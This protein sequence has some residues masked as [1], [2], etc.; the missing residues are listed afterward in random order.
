MLTLHSRASTV[1]YAISIIEIDVAVVAS[2]WLLCCVNRHIVCVQT[3][4]D[5]MKQWLMHA[6]MLCVI[7]DWQTE[8]FCDGSKKLQEKGCRTGSSSWRKTWSRRV[9]ARRLLSSVK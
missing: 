5:E 3:H 9:C 4:N 6:A 8:C 2:R 7:C 1:S